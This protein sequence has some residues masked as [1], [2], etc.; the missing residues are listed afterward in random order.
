[1][2]AVDLDRLVSGPPCS[3]VRTAKGGSDYEPQL[4]VG[5]LAAPASARSQLEAYGVYM[6]LTDYDPRTGCWNRCLFSEA[7][8]DML[9]ELSAE[10]Q[11]PYAFEAVPSTGYLALLETGP[12]SETPALPLRSWVMFV[13]VDVLV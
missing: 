11:F 9:S 4:L 6:N 3:P 10:G 8:A 13:L 2:S 5:W 7:V 1:M 12:D